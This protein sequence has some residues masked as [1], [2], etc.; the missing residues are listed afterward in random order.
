MRPGEFVGR[1]A[2]S[3]QLQDVRRNRKQPSSC[4]A[5]FDPAEEHAADCQNRG[6]AKLRTCFR[7][8]DSSPDVDTTITRSRSERVTL[9]ATQVE[10]LTLAQLKVQFPLLLDLKDC[11]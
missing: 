3:P 5:Y 2:S 1:S 4:G 10:S 9:A 6:Q 11:Y 7:R 8:D